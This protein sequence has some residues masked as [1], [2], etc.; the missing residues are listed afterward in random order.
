MSLQAGGRGGGSREA[1]THRTPGSV[2][3]GDAAAPIGP[4]R[5]PPPPRSL[6][7]GGGGGRLTSPF[8]GPAGRLARPFPG[9]AGRL[10]PHSPQ[11][12]PAPGTRRS[13]HAAAVSNGR[14]EAPRPGLSR[15]ARGRAG[16]G[17]RGGGG[18]SKP[19]GAVRGRW[20]PFPGLLP[21]LPAAVRFI[22]RC[23]FGLRRGA[24]A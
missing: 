17:A 23:R 14:R 21:P 22:S 6:C 13:L 10:S 15:G 24:S 16:D 18:V 9:P 1:R 20:V 12:H 4:L 2:F 8:S 19:G 7:N 11:P 3:K 5:S